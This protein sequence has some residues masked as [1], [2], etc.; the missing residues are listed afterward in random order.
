MS[1]V[2]QALQK[3]R[4]Q[5][6][7]QMAA[8]GGT[9][10]VPYHFSPPRGAAF[11]WKPIL[12]G[13]ILLGGG[14]V[15]CWLGGIGFPHGPTSSVP[16]PAA[17]RATVTHPLAED[18]GLIATTQP[19][20]VIT[21]L[22]TVKYPLSISPGPASPVPTD[23]ASLVAQAKPPATHPAKLPIEDKPAA[24][25]VALKEAAPD[26][27]A[28]PSAPIA[29]PPVPAAL[30][31]AP[32]EPVRAPEPVKEPAL[33]NAQTLDVPGSGKLKLMAV[34]RSAEGWAA[35]INETIVEEGD[36]VDSATVVRI[37]N[38]RVQLKIGAK[39][40]TLKLP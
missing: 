10:G 6:T 13:T 32:A 38:K 22:D 5:Q 4:A 2:N 3:V 31:P 34:S 18:G 17:A 28:L 21:V 1:L 40:F 12:A 37:E 24:L 7:Q 19:H 30:P 14:V 26:P 16:N 29:L 23:V 20:E 33:V 35:V 11:R 9:G 15:A 27:V 39:T 36:Q 25:V 8:N